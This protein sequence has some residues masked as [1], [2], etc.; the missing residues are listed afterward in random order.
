MG[1]E[2]L[3]GLKSETKGNEPGQATI[4]ICQRIGA[5]PRR[6]CGDTVE[7]LQTGNIG[8]SDANLSQNAKTGV[9]S[10]G[11]VHLLTLSLCREW[12]ALHERS[13]A[14]RL[15]GRIMERGLGAFFPKSIWP[16]KPNICNNNQYT[17]YCG[18]QR[19]GLRP[20]DDCFGVVLWPH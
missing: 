16:R 17:I 5:A 19:A 18:N 8:I 11:F 6:K 3:G 13:V 15:P 10:A 20:V 14:V 2:G 9:G 12:R 1:S 4:D 7:S